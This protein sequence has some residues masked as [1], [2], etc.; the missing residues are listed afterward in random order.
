MALTSNDMLKSIIKELEKRE[1]VKKA[2][3]P[4][5]D[6]H[7]ITTGKSSDIIQRGEVNQLLLSV[8]NLST[9]HKNINLVWQFLQTKGV[10]RGL[11]DG[12]HVYRFIIRKE[13]NEQ[14]T[15]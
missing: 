11:H 12:K 13:K 7:F 4:V 2:L 5:F 10:K 14:E 3:D 9:Y 1:E 6:Q 8:L 15:N